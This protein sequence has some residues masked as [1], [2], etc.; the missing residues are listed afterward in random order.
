MNI[1][2]LFILLLPILAAF[3]DGEPP[4]QAQYDIHET[5]PEYFMTIETKTSSQDHTIVRQLKRQLKRQ[6]KRAIH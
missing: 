2:N 5:Y 1:G 4:K 3:P 6:F